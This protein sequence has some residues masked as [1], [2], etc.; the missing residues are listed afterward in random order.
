MTPIVDYT[1]WYERR[2]ANN[3]LEALARRS[4]CGVCD[5]GLYTPLVD[6]VITPRCSKDPAHQGMA[7]PTTVMEAYRQGMRIEPATEAAIDNSRRRRDLPV[8]ERDLAPQG[9]PTSLPPMTAE[10][11]ERARKEMEEL[12]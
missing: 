10:E 6:G 12:L 8:P 5:A 3:D 7:T 1:A 9:R 2:L 4:V 11:R